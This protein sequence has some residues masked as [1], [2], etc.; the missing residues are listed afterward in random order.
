MSTAT[1]KKSGKKKSP[2]IA[3]EI[4]DGERR[5]L[6]VKG[7]LAKARGRAKASRVT[8]SFREAPDVRTTLDKMYDQYKKLAYGLP[9]EILDYVELLATWNPDYSQA[10]EN[11]KMLA[12]SG[13]QLYV[14]A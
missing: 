12:N 5:K 1:A 4:S 14:D 6:S 13:H 8:S 2:R 11:I 9:W 10:V 7:M 3:S